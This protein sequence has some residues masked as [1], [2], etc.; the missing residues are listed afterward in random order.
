MITEKILRSNPA[1]IKALTGLPAGE[2]WQ[3]IAEMKAK[4]PEYERQRHER[5]DRQRAVGAGHPCAQSLVI[6]T[7]A[8]L[9]YLR[10]HIPQEVVALLFGTTQAY[11]SRDLRRLLPLIAQII[12]VPEEW[13]IVK[14]SDEVRTLEHLPDGCEVEADKGY[15]GLDKQVTLVVVRN[16]ETGEEQQVPRLHIKTPFKKPKV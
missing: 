6:C 8:V 14:L 16:P 1:L 12:P 10:L 5:P 4:E 9:T 15:Q 2:F 7:A 3:L 11:I 13:E